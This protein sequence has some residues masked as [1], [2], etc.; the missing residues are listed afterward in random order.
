MATRDLDLSVEEP[1]NRADAAVLRETTG[2]TFRWE[3]GPAKM[4]VATNE[5]QSMSPSAIGVAM[6]LLSAGSSVPAVVLALANQILHAPAVLMATGSIALF[7]VVF[8]TGTLLMLHGGAVGRS[9]QAPAFG[10]RPASGR[11]HTRYRRL[12]PRRRASG[13]S[14]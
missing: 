2:L 7:L 6:L 3:L 10:D 12:R 1:S 14:R 8:T 5:A 9:P 11:R 4:E 13:S